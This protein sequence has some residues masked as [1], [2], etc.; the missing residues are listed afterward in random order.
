MLRGAALRVTRP[1]VAVLSAVH[2]HPHADTDTIIGAVRRDLPSVS[3]QAVYDVLRALTDGGPG[4]PHPAVRL[5]RALRGAGRRQPPPRRVPLVRRHRRRRL[6]RRRGALPDRV[7]RPRLRD[8]RGR[9]H[10]LG[11]VP[12]LLRHHAPDHTATPEGSHDRDVRRSRTTAARARTRRSTRP[13]PKARP[14]A[15][16]PG[17]VA[18]PARPV[19]P[20]RSTR[21][22][23]P[24]GRGLRLRRGVREARRRGAQAGHRRGDDAPRRTG[25]R[26]TSATT[27]ACSSG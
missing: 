18:E 13:T 14:A 26:P 11:P 1:R 3:H 9:G 8:R 16:Q 21:R 20:A 27:A 10:L 23:Q 5:G 6:R 4:A 22:G 24:D 2:A 15:H 19:G 17:L 25:G 12:R 7:R